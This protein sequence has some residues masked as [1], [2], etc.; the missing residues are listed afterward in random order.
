ML[1][2]LPKLSFWR[3]IMQFCIKIEKSPLEDLCAHKSR[4]QHRTII[5]F[6]L[7]DRCGPKRS[8]KHQPFIS[9]L[10]LWWVIHQNSLLGGQQKSSNGDFSILMQNCMV[11]LQKESFGEWSSWLW[12]SKIFLKKYFWNTLWV[13]QGLLR[14]IS[15]RWRKRDDRTMR[16]TTL[17]LTKVH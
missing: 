16:R 11:D 1:S 10:K 12:D 8:P 6:A 14:I 15:I 17:M 4:S 5:P 3:S 7:E 2:H 9:S 13:F